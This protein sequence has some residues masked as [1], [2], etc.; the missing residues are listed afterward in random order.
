VL[1]NAGNEQAWL[2]DTGLSRRGQEPPDTGAGAGAGAEACG[3][4]AEACGAG[5]ELGWGP[6]PGPWR[7]S[8]AGLASA[9]ITAEDGADAVSVRAPGVGARAPSFRPGAAED[10]AAAIAA[11]AAVAPMISH[12]RARARRPSAASRSSWASDRLRRPAE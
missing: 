4:G 12:R 5:G 1:A 10:T 7:P 9:G 8:W 3:A 2:S 6:S 11:V